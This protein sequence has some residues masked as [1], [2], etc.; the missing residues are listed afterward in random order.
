MHTHPPFTLKGTVTYK[1]AV[2]APAEMADTLPLFHLYR[3]YVQYTLWS[4]TPECMINGTYNRFELLQI[5]LVCIYLSYMY[6]VQLL[7]LTEACGIEI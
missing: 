5:V 2:Y 6:I 3:L 7:A 4:Q 1:D